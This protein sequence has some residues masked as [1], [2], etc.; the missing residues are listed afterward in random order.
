MTNDFFKQYD[1]EMDFGTMQLTW[2]TPTECTDPD[3]VAY[4]SNGGVAVL[5]MQLANGKIQVPVTI[6]GHSFTAVLDTSS[7]HPVMR[8]D[9]AELSLGLKAGE[10]E[11]MAKEGLKDGMGQPIYGH[12]FP[13]IVFTGAPGSNVTAVNVPVMIQSN[14]MIGGSDMVLG[15]RASS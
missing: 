8:R 10:P 9:V 15:S 12:T 6:E 4:W 5:P 2:L 11:M 14:S 1:V 13:K 7:A 3:K